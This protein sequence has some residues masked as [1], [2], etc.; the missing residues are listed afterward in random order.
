LQG[1]LTIMPETLGEL[2]CLPLAE[3]DLRIGRKAS[4]LPVGVL[5]AAMVLV[6]FNVV[7][8]AVAFFGAAVVLLLAGSLSM[9]EAYDAIEWPILV[10][11]G[12]LIP[13]SDALRTT[14]G[15]ELIAAGLAHVAAHMP[16]TAALALLLAA[17]MAVT[18]FLNNAATVLVMA[19]IGASVASKLGYNPDPFLM[20]VAIGAA[21]D[22][23]T[24]IGHQ[25]NT[26]VMGPGGYRFGDYWRLGLPLSLIVLAV[27]VPL[28]AFFWPV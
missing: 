17:A 24:P 22:F 6:A 26:L 5:A 25:C 10:M 13:V 19:P 3:R 2:H 12:A 28:I 7:P 20:A 8:V 27:G 14:G 9:R 18:P 16:A 15:T 11:L 1:N 21:C 4:L 23:L